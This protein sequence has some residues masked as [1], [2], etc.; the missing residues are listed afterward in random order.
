MARLIKIGDGEELKASV[1]QA[2]KLYNQAA[3]IAML[4]FKN[5]LGV[6]YLMLAEE[7]LSL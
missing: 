2:Y 1:N 6:E 5:K 4:K 7:C 3:E